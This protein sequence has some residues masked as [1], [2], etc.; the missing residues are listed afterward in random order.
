MLLQGHGQGVSHE[1]GRTRRAGRDAQT[2]Y[3][4]HPAGRASRPCA[5]GAAGTRRVTGDA[6]ETPATPAVQAALVQVGGDW[7]PGVAVEEQDEGWTT[8]LVPDIPAAASGRLYCIHVAQ[9]RPLACSLDDFRKT[10]TAAGRG[11]QDWLRT[12]AEWTKL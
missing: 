12:L 11:S 9:I 8:V 6:V 1:P 4:D 3:S 7:Q 5:P 2:P 10:L